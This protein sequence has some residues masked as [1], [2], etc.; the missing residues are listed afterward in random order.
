MP[1]GDDGLFPHGIRV[2]G[3]PVVIVVQGGDAPA[4]FFEDQCPGGVVPRSF[5]R[6]QKNIDSPR[7][8]MTPL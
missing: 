8:K 1:C 2:V 7:R 5:A 3:A 4:C 6:M